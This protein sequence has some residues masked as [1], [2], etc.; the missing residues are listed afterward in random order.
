VKKKASPVEKTPA[1][2]KKGVKA[3]KPEE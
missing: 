3:K 2:V 1:D